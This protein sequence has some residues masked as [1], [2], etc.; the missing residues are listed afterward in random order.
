MA[1]ASRHDNR[2][3][4]R[5]AK[6]V[7]L[8]TRCEKALKVAIKTVLAPRESQAAMVRSAVLAE[9]ERRLKAK[10]AKK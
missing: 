10:G 5:M 1:F 6:D 4:I 9:I 8:I 7:V 2:Y 3:T